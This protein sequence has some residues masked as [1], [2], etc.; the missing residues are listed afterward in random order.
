M[1]SRSTDFLTIREHYSGHGVR[2]PQ[3]GICRL[4]ANYRHARPVAFRFARLVS[5]WIFEFLPGFVLSRD[6][7]VLVV[8][9]P[10]SQCR[11]R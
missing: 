11:E 8:A 9:N 7:V 6:C 3:D 10:S 4:T 5:K 1:F 2:W